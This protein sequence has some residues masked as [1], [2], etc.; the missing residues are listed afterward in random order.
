MTTADV[1]DAARSALGPVGAFLPG[2]ILDGAVP[3]ALQREAVQRL[4][5][6]GYRAAWNNEGV[7]DK[8]ALVQLGLML[9]STERMVLGPSIANIWARSPF[10][11]EVAAASLAEAY[12]GRFVLGLGV[13]YDFQA[14][15]VGQPWG[16]PLRNMREYV[17]QMDAPPFMR[18]VPDTPYARIL[19]ARGPK[20]LALSGEIA[21]G[22]NCN[23]VPPEYTARARNVLGPDKLLVIGVGAILDDDLERARTAAREGARSIGRFAVVANSLKGLGYSDEEISAGSDRLA[24][25][26]T[27][28][29]GPTEIAAKVREHL[30]AGADHVMVMLHGTDYA[31]GVDQLVALAPTLHAISAPDRRR[32]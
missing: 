10:T 23:S 27:A 15:M 20:M 14:A 1:V 6:S 11:M 25:A 5:R 28:Y 26:L 9:A 22:A 13:G 16:S 19:A 7:G 12:P 32:P 2:P 29:G 3:A 17:N 8:D 18:Q 21:D 30:D 31:A 4:E 24:D